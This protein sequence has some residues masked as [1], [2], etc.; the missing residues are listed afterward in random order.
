ML[1]RTVMGELFVETY[2][3]FGPA[4]A[5][6]VGQSELLR[7]SARAVLEP[8]VAAIRRLTY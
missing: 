2:Y 6:V 5:G 7:T 3:T 8:I 4:V 1:K